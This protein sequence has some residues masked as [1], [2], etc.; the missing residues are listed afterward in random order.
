M[1][2]SPLSPVLQRLLL[3]AALLVFLAGIQL[4]LLSDDTETLFAWTVR[5]PLTAAFLG[6]LYWSAGLLEWLAARSGTW[7][8]ARIAVIGVLG[9]TVLTNLPT[10]A[11]LDQYHLDRPAAWV[12]IAV[13][14]LVPWLFA[15]ALRAQRS[16][17]WHAPARKHRLPLALKVLL[18]LTGL[19]FL[20]GGLALI[21]APAVAG[22]AW[23]WDLSPQE[24]SYT[25]FSEPYMGCWGVGLG[26]VATQAAWEDELHRLR[27]VWPAMIA[28]PVLCAVAVL[29]Y[30]DAVE[31]RH[32]A[33]EIMVLIFAVLLL[34][35][36]WGELL[37]RRLNR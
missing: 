14:A 25:R 24:G 30:R 7:A 20:V 10:W 8:G 31:W 5:P 33:T 26:L 13:Y 17:G 2:P 29:R 32:P 22:A 18:G 15:G 21:A 28:A 9:F 12:W 19:A 34:T 35:G 23:P 11:N 16:V 4:F 36:I 1:Q 3:A 37:T 6:A 27:P